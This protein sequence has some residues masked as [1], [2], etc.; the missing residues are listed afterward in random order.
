MYIYLVKDSLK[1]DTVKIVFKERFE[2]K[3]GRE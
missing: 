3:E 1:E 2:R